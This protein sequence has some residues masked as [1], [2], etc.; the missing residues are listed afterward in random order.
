MFGKIRRDLVPRPWLYFEALLPTALCL[1]FSVEQIQTS[2]I[3][4]YGLSW[5]SSIFSHSALSSRL[6]I[7]VSSCCPSLRNQLSCWEACPQHCA[8]TVTWL[9]VRS[10]LK[11]QYGQRLYTHLHLFLGHPRLP[12]SLDS[13][14]SSGVAM[15]V[16]RFEGSRLKWTGM[17]ARCCTS[18][19]VIYS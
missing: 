16:S 19:R 10:V 5:C 15:G 2:I 17:F 18:E 8:D 7:L 1:C 6:L 13:P 4:F 9:L 12:V 14:G 11:I 3:L